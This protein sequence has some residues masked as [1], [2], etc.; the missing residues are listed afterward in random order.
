[1][2]LAFLFPGQG[3]QAVGM[4][5]AL[6]DAFPAARATFAEAD[7]AL[8]FPLSAICWEGPPERLRE[9]RYTQPALLTHGVAA[10]RLLEERGLRPDWSAG[11]V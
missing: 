11:W 4:G 2:S 9:T 1:M 10:W 3:A 8:G 5:R 6:A 7:E